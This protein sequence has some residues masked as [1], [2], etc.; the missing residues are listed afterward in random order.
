MPTPFTVS[1][2]VGNGITIAGA[3]SM[4]IAEIIDVKLPDQKAGPINV[5]TMAMTN[6]GEVFIPPS[7]WDSGELELSILFNP[8]IVLPFNKAYEVWTITFPKTPS[9]AT[10]AATW[11]FSGSIIEIGGKVP[12]KD[13]MSATIKIKVSGNITQTPQA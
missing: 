8:D 10:T 11:S 2:A 12:I 7:I 4:A 5:T 3:T 6:Q 9:T 13:K 1:G